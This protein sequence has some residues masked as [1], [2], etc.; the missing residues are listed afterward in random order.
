MPIFSLLWIIPAII[1]VAIIVSIIKNHE[2]V[3]LLKEITG[4]FVVIVL[5]GSILVPTISDYDREDVD[6][7]IIAG[8]S[9][10]AYLHYDIDTCDPKVGEGYA[11]YYGTSI[12]P[13]IY[14]SHSTPTYDPTL[15]SYSI[16]SANSSNLAHLESPFSETYHEKTGHDVVTINVGISGS[17]IQEWQSNGF[18]WS[19]AT[20]VINDALEK[21]SNYDLHLMGFI[22]IQGESDSSMTAEDYTSYFLNT[23]ELFKNK[24]FADCFISKV[25]C[26]SSTS[27]QRNPVGPSNAQIAMSEEYPHIHM[28][29]QIADTFTVSNGLMESDN[30]HY[31]QLGQNLIGVAVGEYCA[32]YY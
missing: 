29:T 9:N 18:A 12:S 25:R 10:A 20:T 19:Y 1:L 31:N 14:G 6:I 8:Q 13:I 32:N 28:A 26:D 3:G 17:S 11:Y 21:L 30:L 4:V 15:E 16:Q 5:V 23:F 22:W 27:G 24:G 2:N 7:F